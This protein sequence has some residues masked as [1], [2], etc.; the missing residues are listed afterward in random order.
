MAASQIALPTENGGERKMAATATILNTKINLGVGGYRLPPQL[1]REATEAEVVVSF[2]KGREGNA[3]GRATDGKVVL[4]A[5]SAPLQPLPGEVWRGKM[6]ANPSGRFYHFLPQECLQPNTILRNA[7]FATVSVNGKPAFYLVRVTDATGK[8]KVIIVAAGRPLAGKNIVIHA[9]KLVEIA[10]RFTLTST[11]TYRDVLERIQNL[12]ALYGAENVKY[13]SAK[14][15]QLFRDI[16][17]PAKL[18]R[19]AHSHKLAV[20]RHVQLDPRDKESKTVI[21]VE[22]CTI[23]GRWTVTEPERVS[24]MERRMGLPRKPRGRFT[25]KSR[26]PKRAKQNVT[27]TGKGMHRRRVVHARKRRQGRW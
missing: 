23:C 22:R 1:L 24:Q 5:K 21:A 10:K 12:K 15:K 27:F 8:S 9:H 11:V 17:E 19:F 18:P 14:L 2:V 6:W 25:P 26:K 3:I 20:E 7:E 4:P 16:E 13:D